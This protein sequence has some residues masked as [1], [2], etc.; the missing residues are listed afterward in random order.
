MAKKS[1]DG[2]RARPQTRSRRE[3]YA[4]PRRTHTSK[5]PYV[6]TILI[7]HYPHFVQVLMKGFYI[8][9]DG[10]IITAPVAQGAVAHSRG[11]AV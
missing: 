6:Y 7:T 8:G 9:D 3:K 10:V 1:K 2:L 4:V 11:G 5:I